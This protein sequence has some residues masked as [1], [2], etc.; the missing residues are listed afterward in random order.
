[1]FATDRVRLRAAVP[2]DA[3]DLVGIW[4]DPE[5][6]LLASGAPF[7]PK[8]VPSVRASLEKDMSETSET[9]AGFVAVAAGDGTLL[10]RCALWGIDAYNQEAHIGLSLVPTARGHGYGRDVVQLLCR[11]GFRMRN[12]HR[13]EIETFAH[14]MSMRKT[15][16]ACGFT[17]EG[18][19]RQKGWTGEGYGDLALYG[20]LR[21]EWAS[22]GHPSR[23]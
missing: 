11:Y 3:A 5:T 19:Q 8:S 20:L 18:T 17:L 4:G 13:L 21:T 23:A 7:V 1:M 9:F 10:G 16:E 15:A 12:L 6:H 14:N 22:P 2:D